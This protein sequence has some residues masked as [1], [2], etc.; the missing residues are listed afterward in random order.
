MSVN[1]K[2]R[3]FIGQSQNIC[4]TL[5]D[6]MD[7]FNTLSNQWTDEF[8]T[9]KINEITQTE[10]DELGLGITVTDLSRMEPLGQNIIKLRDNQAV[11]QA[12][13]GKYLRVLMNKYS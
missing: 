11:L 1:Q 3:A 9:G 7:R 13:Y 6:L 8:K 5:I 10:L 4:S 12:D 2:K